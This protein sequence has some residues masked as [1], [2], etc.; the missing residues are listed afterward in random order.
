MSP[1]CNNYT[2]F[3]VQTEANQQRLQVYSLYT[4]YLSAES[5][6]P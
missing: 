6:Q 5:L 3:A 4:N 1:S 2:H